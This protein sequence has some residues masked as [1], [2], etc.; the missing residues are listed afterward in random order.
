MGDTARACHG[1][2][3]GAGDALLVRDATY[4]E[5]R[6]YVL[7]VLSRR[8]RWLDSDERE[9]AFHDAYAVLLE[10]ERDGRLDTAAMHPQRSR[11]PRTCRPS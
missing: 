2:G 5:H 10:K 8:C 6:D 9:A 1:N 7:M 3:D 4:E 11:S